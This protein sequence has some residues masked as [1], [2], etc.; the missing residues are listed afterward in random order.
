MLSL[1]NY[2]IAQSIATICHGTTKSL[3][4][5]V[6]RTCTCTYHRSPYIFDHDPKPGSCSLS[7]VLSHHA[8]IYLARSI[9]SNQ[10]YS[11]LLSRFRD[12]ITK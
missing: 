6:T 1:Y 4:H 2:I 3:V 11:Q 12:T 7:N 8:S 9:A 10:A 5:P